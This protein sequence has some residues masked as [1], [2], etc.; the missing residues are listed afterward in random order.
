MK[1]ELR[2]KVELI[3]QR[4]NSAED[5]VRTNETVGQLASKSC[6]QLN[7]PCVEHNQI[8]FLKS[9]VPALVGNLLRLSIVGLKGI[10]P[11][12]LQRS[13]SGLEIC[14]GS[15]CSFAMWQVGGQ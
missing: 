6:W 2:R 7:V 9:D 4:A 11:G 3:S 14:V 15:W 12:C 1:L 5:T 8:T 10:M 13:D